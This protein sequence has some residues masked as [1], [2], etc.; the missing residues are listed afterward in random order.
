MKRWGI[1]CLIGFL[2]LAVSTIPAVKLFAAPTRTAAEEL[3]SLNKL[4]PAE[5]KT[6]LEEEAAREGKVIM[7]GA[8]SLG[9]AEKVF[10][11]FMQKYPKV[12]VEYFR[13]STAPL[14]DKIL[15]EASVGKLHADVAN[16]G[17][18][19]LYEVEKMTIPYQAPAADAF[20]KVFVDPK[21]KWIALYHDPKPIAYNTKRVTEAEAPK[22]WE[23]LTNPRWK[24]R[25]GMPV[26]DGPD[27]I[28]IM[29]KTMG[30]DKGRD[31]VKRM[32]AQGI[33]LEKSNS[34][35]AQLVAAGDLDVAFYVNNA[36]VEIAKR[37]GAPIVA[38]ATEPLVTAIQ[39]LVIFKDAAHPYAS[40]LFVDWLTSKEG[41]EMIKKV[42]PR[43]G[44]RKDVSYP[45]AFAKR[46]FL[47]IGAEQVDKASMTEAD[48]L[49][50]DW[51]VKR[52]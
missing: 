47:V 52:K 51:F 23:D 12:K 6:R 21:S 40:A 24:G 32:A 38:V 48:K 44:A 30:K 9:E 45:E 22:N 10:K 41:Q 16:I 3:A 42:N 25:M 11:A 4:S 46:K 31:Y 15:S 36:A 28:N 50:E 26:S 27:W 5:R 1:I 13:A 8:Y 14:L 19:V 49:F 34:G 2:V 33:R 17:L 18:E 20:G 37:K 39:V 7:Y 35:L 43:F 29:M